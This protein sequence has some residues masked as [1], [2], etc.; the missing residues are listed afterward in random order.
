M[1]QYRV[2]H[3]RTSVTELT[4]FAN[5]EADIHNTFTDPFSWNHDRLIKKIEAIESEV[6][7]SD[8]SIYIKIENDNDSRADIYLSPDL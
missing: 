2:K 1:P 5:S 8:S 4:I 3:Y 6:C 7:S